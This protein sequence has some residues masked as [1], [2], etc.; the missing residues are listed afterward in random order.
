MSPAHAMTLEEVESKPS[1]KAKRAIGKD[2]KIKL[3]KGTA[4]NWKGTIGVEQL[5]YTGAC[6]SIR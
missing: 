6:V 1:R 5:I 2:E 3:Q 4:V